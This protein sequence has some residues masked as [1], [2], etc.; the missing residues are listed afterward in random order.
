[1]TPLRALFPLIALCA[2]VA[3]AGVS[4]RAQEIRAV[5]SVDRFYELRDGALG[6]TGPANAHLYRQ[7]LE[8]V[9]GAAAHGLEPADY[10]LAALRAGD[11]DPDGLRLDR[12]ATDAYLT[13][14]AHLLSGRLNPVTVEP[15]WTAARRE[16]DLAVYLHAA[17]AQGAVRTSLDALGPMQ[18]G[19]AALKQALS[20][21]RAIADRGGWQ[22]VD[23]GAVL[24]RGDTGPRVQQLRRRLRATGDVEGTEGSPDAFDAALDIAVR[25]FQRRAN[26]EPDGIVGPATLAQLNVSVQ[27]RI[28]QIRANMER[29]RWLP[30]DLGTRH[31]RVNI[32]DY[33]LE[34]RSGGEVERVHEV[35]V[36]QL[37][38]KTPVFSGRMTYL[39]LNPWWETPPSLAVRDK[40]PAFRKNPE[41]VTALGF[42][43]IDREGRTVDPAT[44]DWSTVTARNFPFRIRQAPG[45][46][47]ALGDV[48]FMFPN[49]HNVYLHDTPTRGLFA[50]TRRDFSSGCIRVK[51]PLRL[52]AWAAADTPGWDEARIEAVAAGNEETRVSLARPVQVHLLYWTVVP[53]DETGVRFLADIYERDGRL[54]EALDG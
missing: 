26:L 15:D 36:G 1:M 27:G 48:K 40:L 35:V 43:V 41:M 8:S 20:Q 44:I 16:R 3:S 34:A 52:A 30:E 49:R 12:I 14:A 31:I 25:R 11:P 39:V 51:D 22:P 6:W 37:F 19:Y 46:Q 21:Y 10:H 45:P 42:Q 28:A 50:K 29:W 33:R 38:R 23:S 9:E 53:E 4:A 17:L 47:N 5:V 18:P 32:A 2:A 54:I 24:R 13:L 7:L